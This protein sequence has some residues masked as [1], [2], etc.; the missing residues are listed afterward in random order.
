MT[1]GQLLGE[2][3]KRHQM[4]QLGLS[5]AAG[6]TRDAIA[7]I[8][9]GRRPITLAEAAI[10]SEVLG[11]DLRE[12]V[13]REEILDRLRAIAIDRL[14]TAQARL[15]RADREMRAARAFAERVGK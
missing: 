3:R 8:E 7:S 14:E 2:A 4:T 13:D 11:I 12:L 1:I 6:L 10:V 5:E 9:S 15:E